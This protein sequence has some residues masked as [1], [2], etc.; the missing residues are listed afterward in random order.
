MNNLKLDL[1]GM[2]CKESKA[3]RE[4]A[5]R[6]KA[7]AE[8]YSQRCRRIELLKCGLLGIFIIL[9]AGI[10]GRIECST[11]NANASV[12]AVI[13]E[14]T[15]QEEAV[16]VGYDEEGNMIL[17]TKDGNEWIVNDPP[18]V[19]YSVTFDNKGTDDITDDEIIGLE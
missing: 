8:A 15:R 13:A 17:R 6:R 2:N 4:R 18:E 12:E 10:V 19:W 1:A 14:N 9:A 11:S 5:E 7:N 3:E 16:L